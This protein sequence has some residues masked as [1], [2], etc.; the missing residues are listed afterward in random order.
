M[1]REPEGTTSTF[2]IHVYIDL[3]IHESFVSFLFFG[4]LFDFSKERER[5]KERWSVCVRRAQGEREK[6]VRECENESPAPRM[7]G[8]PPP[9]PPK[10]NDKKKKL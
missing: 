5:T 8:I 4:S 1:S 9:P 3:H 10:P 7:P 2:I 6:R